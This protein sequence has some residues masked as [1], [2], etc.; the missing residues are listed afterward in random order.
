VGDSNT[1]MQYDG[2]GRI[3]AWGN[4]GAANNTNDYTTA[5]AGCTY[6]ANPQST[7]FAKDARY[8][9]RLVLL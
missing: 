9:R 8:R 3:S 6:Y 5:Q 1:V 4:G 7:L 2:M